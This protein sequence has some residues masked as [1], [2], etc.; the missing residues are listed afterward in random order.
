MR[1]LVVDDAASV[2]QRIAAVLNQAPEIEAVYEAS[3]GEEALTLLES[4]RPD[5]MTLDLMLPG[6]T[7]L[8]VLEEVRRRD[9][10]VKVVVITNYPYPA[11]K[12]KCLDLGAI[13]FLPKNTGAREV[14]ELLRSGSFDRASG[15]VPEKISPG[16]EA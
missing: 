12:K 5:L 1:V 4:F 2:R 3:A 10:S 8:E 14:V 6:M 11:F 15:E 7:G 13:Y 16:T 9:I